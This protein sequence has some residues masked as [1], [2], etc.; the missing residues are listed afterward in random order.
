[1]IYCECLEAPVINALLLPSYFSFL[2]GLGQ[3]KGQSRRL[4]KGEGDVGDV[5]VH[6]PRGGEEKDG[7][8]VSCRSADRDQSEHVVSKCG[9]C[10]NGASKT[11]TGNGALV[12][13]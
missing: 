11:S 7:G 12:V 2:S 1:M 6:G 9:R 8:E 5:V 10:A 13:L 4:G 3:Y